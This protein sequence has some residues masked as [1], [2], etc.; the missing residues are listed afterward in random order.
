MW[1][2]TRKPGITPK[3]FR[4]HYE[5]SHVALAHKYI[6]HLLTEYRRNYKVETAGGP[7]FENSGFAPFDWEY[8]VITE[9]VLPDA[10]ALNEMFRIFSDPVI[11]QEFYEDEFNFMDRSKTIMFKCEA[12]DTG[13]GDGGG[14]LAVRVNRQSIK[15]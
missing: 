12:V 9:F 5:R 8:D 14:S 15:K 7:Y 13:T 1:L 11:G 10:A 3:Q 4:A 2:L 6:G